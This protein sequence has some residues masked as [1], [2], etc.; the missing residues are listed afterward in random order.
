MSATQSFCFS[1]QP[2]SEYPVDMN[3]AAAVKQF[4]KD[5]PHIIG[6]RIPKGMPMVVRSGNSNDISA[7]RPDLTCALNQANSLP[8]QS[9]RNI[10]DMVETFGGDVIVAM[11]EFYAVEVQPVLEKYSV[12]AAGAAATA[13][14]ERVSQFGKSIIKYQD[15]LLKVREGAKAKLPKH[16]MVMLEQIA[17][18]C[19]QEFNGRFQTEFGKFLG[20]VKSGKRGNVWTNPNRGIAIA[21]TSRHPAKL[22]LTSTNSFNSIRRFEAGAKL[23]GGGMIVLDAGIRARSVREDFYAGRDWHRSAVVE[24]TGFGLGTAAGLWVGSQVVMSALGV[25]LLA[26]PV[27]WVLAVGGAIAMGTLASVALD[28]VGQF[29]AGSAYDISSSIKW[30]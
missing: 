10:A 18:R 13:I 16:Q 7:L 2:Y 9:R 12:G 4:R 22:N 19:Y 17:K 15:A 21:K 1:N 23:F 26:T 29:I 5:N 8:A 28:E 27:G 14:D 25:A 6:P 24:T 30:R 3:D 11:S 20:R